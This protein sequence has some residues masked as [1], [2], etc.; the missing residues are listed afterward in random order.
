MSTRA[1]ECTAAHSK[2]LQQKGTRRL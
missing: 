1:G 2:Q